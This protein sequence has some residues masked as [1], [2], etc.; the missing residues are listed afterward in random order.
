[1]YSKK[2]FYF[3]TNPPLNKTAG[4][5]YWNA[6]LE[7][8][9]NKLKYLFDHG[10]LTEDKKKFLFKHFVS[11]I[12]IETSKFC[13]RKCNYC[14][15]KFPIYE[16]NLQKL[17][18][19]DLWNKF[20]KNINEIDYD[21]V[22]SMSLYNEVTKDPF[23]YQRI[24]DIKINAPHCF[25]KFYSNGD[26]INYKVINELAKA[27]L[28]SIYITL[29]AAHGKPYNDDDRLNYIKKFFKRIKY[30]GVVDSIVPNVK[31]TSDFYFDNMRILLMCNNWSVY[32]N[33]RAGLINDMSLT[34]SRIEPCLRPFREF[35]IA[36]TGQ[37]FPC[38]QIFPDEPMHAKHQ[39][40]DLNIDNI[41]DIY[42]SRSISEWR[43]SLFDYGVKTSPC[44]TCG[45]CSFAS[46]SD[47]EFRLRLLNE[48][49]YIH[50]D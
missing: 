16:R 40:G 48:F 21:A 5:Q 49:R 10:K 6:L 39:I 35:T 46:G 26:F 9:V 18:N 34:N 41:W 44:N 14:P 22:I 28:D 19:A 38:C 15:V 27:G 11:I 31:I 12:N 7:E 17:I 47:S 1:M 30:N 37:V 32:G 24:K 20:L 36:H 4:S 25:L 50:T 45:D 2:T 43:A 29:H 23:V 33:D 3:E 8:P 13:N 42:L